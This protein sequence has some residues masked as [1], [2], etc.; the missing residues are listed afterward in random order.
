MLKV[1]ST[2]L[3]PTAGTVRV[4]G[5]DVVRE[6]RA[7]R[8]VLSV[9]LGGERGFY[10]RLSGRDNIRFFGTLSGLP[11]RE[12]AARADEAL[13]QVGLSVA[14]D[15]RVETYSKGM[16]QRLHLAVGML[17]TPKLL[18]LD[19]PTVGLDPLEAERLRTSIA[20]LHGSGTAV[21]LTSHY[22]GDIE[23]LARRIVVLQRGRVT[24]DLPLERLLERAGRAAEVAIS[25]SGP[26]PEPEIAER[27]GVRLVNASPGPPW[28]LRF[29]VRDWSPDSLRA[30]AELWPSAEVTDVRVQPASLEQVFAELARA[31]EGA[32]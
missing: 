5:H 17:T 25:G 27:E 16:K 28:T 23:R 1:I 11:R 22:L 32:A 8:E 7:A 19:E 31:D 26:L 4:D 20:Q 9:V 6:T 15:R 10:N 18:L 2:L 21:L 13:E 29:E 3:L 14:A 30:L 24:H 12:V